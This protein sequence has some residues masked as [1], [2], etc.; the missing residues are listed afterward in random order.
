MSDQRATETPPGSAAGL[1]MGVTAFLIWGITPAYWKQIPQISPLEIVLH[2]ITWS[3]LFLMPIILWRG[4]WRDFIAVFTQPKRLSVLAITSALVSL[5]WLLYIWAVQ[6]GHILQASL[7]YYINPLVNVLM[8]IVFLGERLRRMQLA[9][10]LVAS[11]GVGYLT[12]FVGVFPWVSLTLAFSFA[13]Y[14]LIRKVAAVG[15][16][17]GLTIETLLLSIPA[18]IGLAWLHASDVGAFLRDGWTTDIFLIGAALVTALP[19]LLFNVS[20]RRLR[21]STIG[22]IQYIGPTCMF[23]IGVLVYHEPFA[24]PQLISYSIIWTA[25]VLYTMDSFL[26]HR[27]H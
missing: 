22:F 6:N 15:P 23:L 14:A 13:V 4:Q 5:N 21:L 8:G 11:M 25:L 20:A 24:L 19:L 2:R 12:F 18:T 7:G 16:L 26:H 10:L 3:F 1:I 9:A 17:V 27:H